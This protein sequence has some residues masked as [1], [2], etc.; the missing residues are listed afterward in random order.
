M[1]SSTAKIPG[2]NIV[3]DGKPMVHNGLSGVE[4]TFKPRAYQLEMLEE[5]MQKNIIVAVRLPWSPSS[6]V[7][8]TS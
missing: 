5:S 8:Y 2:G 7:A 3:A 4:S 1:S 6:S